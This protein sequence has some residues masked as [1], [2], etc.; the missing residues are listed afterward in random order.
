MMQLDLS[1][2]TAVL[3]WIHQMP[4]SEAQV[5][6]PNRIRSLSPL[7]SILENGRVTEDN[8]RALTFEEWASMWRDALTHKRPKELGIRQKLMYNN[9]L[10][11]T[12][13]LDELEGVLGYLL[14]HS[15]SL[16]QQIE[17]RV[18]NN[19][20][21]GATLPPSMKLVLGTTSLGFVTQEG[22]YVDHVSLY[23]FHDDV[24][25]VEDLLTHESWHF[26][27][28][29]LLDSHPHRTESWFLPLAQLQ[30]EGIVNYL[31]GGT[32]QIHQYQSRYAEG[33]A[34]KQSRH[35]VQYA[36]TMQD[37]LEPRVR[38]LFSH[39]E[40]LMVGD[41]DSY[42]RYVQ[43][44]PDIPG[45]LHGVVMARAID[46]VFGREALISSTH[47]PLEFIVLAAQAL[48]VKGIEVGLPGSTVHHWVNLCLR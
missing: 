47:D 18:R 27:H 17:T 20:P 19:L 40:R 12:R 21:R 39:L 33:E 11:T 15:N 3:P 26:G 43:T 6:M 31:I 28:S 10:T 29:S 23:M 1:F 46:E 25:T 44:L 13:Q 14:Q 48:Q 4:S 35:F 7:R 2:V 9:M 22:I 34:R 45:Y 5:Q 41:T 38:E 36:D 42:S 8:N 30:S 32:Y 37:D 16:G 24:E